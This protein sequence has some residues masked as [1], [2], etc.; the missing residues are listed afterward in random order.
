MFIDTHCHLVNKNSNDLTNYVNHAHD[1]NVDILVCAC[2]DKDDFSTAINI[3][4]NNSNI[5]CTLGIHPDSAGTE[6]GHVFDIDFNTE[7]K[8]IGIGEIGLDY[9]FGS[10]NKNL[11][12]ELFEQQLNIAK[13]C[14]LPV[15]IHARDAETDT[16]NMLHSDSYGVIHC[17]TGTW[18]FAKK[19][20][21]KNFFFSASGII[22]FK[23]AIDIRETFS[24][25][26]LDRLVIETDAPYCAPVPYRGQEC[27]SF[28]IPATASVLASI[29]SVSVPELEQQLLKNTLCL[30]P[31]IIL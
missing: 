11:Q 15:A 4:N 25:I 23:N 29:K 18:D 5:Y 8:I 3:A 26:P 19:L 2:A 31:R 13:Q 24:K 20:L 14:D 9:H 12:L 27:E 10:D 7:T 28:M 16:L 21:D 22:T 1:S 17:F 6:I 30:Y